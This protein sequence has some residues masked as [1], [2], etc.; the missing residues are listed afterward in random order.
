MKF[1][2]VALLASA[3][4]SAETFSYWIEPCNTEISGR[5]RCEATDPQLAQWAINAWQQAS[6]NSVRFA[7]TQERHAQIR[8]Y[9][10][11]GV[12]SLYGEA[13]RILVDQRP[14]ATVYVRP[15]LSQLGEDVDRLGT[16]D[17]LFREAVVYLTCVHE[18]GHALGMRHTA[19]F[20]DI[21][22]SFSNGGDIG[23][24]FMRYRHELKNRN[25]IRRH[26]GISMHDAKLLADRVAR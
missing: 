26:S 15:D 24:Y 11:E 16:S 14:G 21:M 18:V 13:R 5:S 20:A 4:L 2:A 23:E 25:D 17:R 7:L 9:W 6:G 19:V 22:Y 3:S 12:R 1:V 10:A 8:I